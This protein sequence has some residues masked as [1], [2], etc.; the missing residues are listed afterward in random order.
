M[1]G[2]REHPL[3]PD[4]RHPVTH[5]RPCSLP[6]PRVLLALFTCWAVSVLAF[7]IVQL[8]PGDCRRLYRRSFR[9]GQR[10]RL[11]RRS[12]CAPSTRSIEL[13]VCPGSSLDAP[14]SRGDLGMAMEWRRRSLR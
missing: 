10:H 5:V 14:E 11:S 6:D 1:S 12:R 13:Y 9:L 8:P 4:T 7:V 2:M 3:T